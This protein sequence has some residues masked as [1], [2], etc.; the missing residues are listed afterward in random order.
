MRFS[1]L[2]AVVRDIG[3]RAGNPRNSEGAFLDIPEGLLFVYSR[4]RGDTAA[5]HAR[6][7]LALLR[8]LD[9][10]RSFL[11]EGVIL[12]CEGEGG[13]NMMCPSLMRME[14]GDVGLF[15]LVRITYTMTKIFLRR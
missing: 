10:G 7:D 11:D 14:N 5:D 3:P 8:S 9:G 4:F 15:Y 6:A 2:G 13:V 1:E 12:T